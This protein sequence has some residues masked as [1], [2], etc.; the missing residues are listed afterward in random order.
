MLGL[1]LAAAMTWPMA[2][3]FDRAEATGLKLAPQLF[4]GNAAHFGLR[5]DANSLSIRVRIAA[6]SL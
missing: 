1:V 3:K 6:Q 2:R 5:S 4:D